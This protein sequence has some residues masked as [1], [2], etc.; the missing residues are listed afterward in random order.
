MFK[1]KFKKTFKKF[2][3]LNFYGYFCLRFYQ[4]FTVNQILKN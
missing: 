3:N 4:I 2:A 1:T